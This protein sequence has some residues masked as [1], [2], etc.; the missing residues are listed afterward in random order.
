MF[1]KHAEL[2]LC[3]LPAVQARWKKDPSSFL[4]LFFDQKTGRSVGA[5]CKV[6]AAERKVYRCVETAELEK[7]AG[8]HHHGGIVAVVT[9]GAE[10][11]PTAEELTA[12][13]KRREPLL[14]LDRIGNPHNL[15]A[16]ARTAAFLGVKH[17]VIPDSP[18]A[19]RGN[20]AAYRVSEGGLEAVELWVVGD[21][22]HFLQR[23]ARA[24]YEVVGAATRDGKLLR[25][26]GAA[27]LLGGE[28][29]VALVLGNEEQGMSS[30]VS[31]SC[32]RLVTLAGSGEVE[33]L[34]VSVAGALLMWELLVPAGASPTAAQ[35]TAPKGA[36]RG[37]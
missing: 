2:K 36:R 29:A 22:P 18:E 26:G 15:G 35:P 5:L 17:M 21:L 9:P 27:K 25:P 10:R 20:D 11:M 28:K 33:S 31:A 1:L 16:L 14:V 12:W 34:N 8:S 7:I 30:A 19:S 4:R 6:L 23:L 24:G 32:T 13:S 3:G 37:V